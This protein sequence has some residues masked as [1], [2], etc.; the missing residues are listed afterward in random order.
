MI[1]LRLAAQQQAAALE[2]EANP[3]EAAP[4]IEGASDNDAGPEAEAQEAAAG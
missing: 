3:E 1:R 2:A 4:A